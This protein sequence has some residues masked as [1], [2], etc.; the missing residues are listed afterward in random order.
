MAAEEQLD[1]DLAGVA[2][3]VAFVTDTTG[4]TVH[5]VCEDPDQAAAIARD[6]ADRYPELSPRIVVE[7]DPTWRF[8]STYAV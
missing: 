4:R 2:T 6:W 7:S 3:S 5:F 1:T 8:R